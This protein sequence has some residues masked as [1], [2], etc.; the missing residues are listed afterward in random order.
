MI[1]RILDRIAQGLLVCAAML[2]FFLSFIVCTDVIGRYFFNS[3][4]KGT[5]EIVSMAIVIIAYLQAAYAIRSGGMIAVDAFYENYPVRLKSLVSLIGSLLGIFMFSLIFFG[6]YERAIDAWVTGEFE[7]EGALRV[8][9]WPAKW[10]LVIGTGL[11]ALSY[12]T[13]AIK[14]FEALLKGTQPPTTSVSH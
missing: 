13:L 2:G 4:L 1:N 9:A 12:F 5:P 7:G 3:P 11:A 14:Q 8:P 10:A 6:S